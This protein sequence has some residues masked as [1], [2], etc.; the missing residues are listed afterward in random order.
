MQSHAGFVLLLACAAAHLAAEDAGNA[1]KNGNF[2]HWDDYSGGVTTT[3]VGVPSGSI[4]KDWY[5]GPGVNATATYD[6]LE[7]TENQTEVPGNPK[8]FFR[9]SWS[10]APEGW[11]GEAHHLPDYRCTFLEYFGMGDVS[12]FA[13]KTLRVSFF[14]RVMEG[15]LDIVPIVWQSRDHVT[16]GITAVKGKGYELFE[17]ADT[18]GEV[19]V[20][21]GRPRPA[22]ICRL[23]TQWQRFQKDITLP[24]MDG[25]SVSPGNY[26]G[27]G[28]DLIEN[29]K[30]TIDIA[31]IVVQPI[32]K[33]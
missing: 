21:Q 29:G 17:A 31:Q 30:P 14:A 23:N 32:S 18:S 7:F 4:A 19:K 15:E 24:G 1:V 8:Y 12:T 9:V 13:G 22:A 16:P 20:A 3:S 26:T 10:K 2:E 25:F 5:G 27:F 28:F 6:R 11:T 33:E